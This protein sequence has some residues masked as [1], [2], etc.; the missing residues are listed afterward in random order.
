MQVLFIAATDP[1]GQ[2]H[3]LARLLRQHSVAQARVM[4]LEEPRL[5]PTGSDL[6]RL[7]DGGNELQHLLSTY[8]TVHLVDLVPSQ[9]PLLADGNKRRFVLQWSRRPEPTQ[10][11]EC[12]TLAGRGARIVTTQPGLVDIHD[13]SF[14]PPLIAT[15]Q[16]PW[17]PLAPGTR[18]RARSDRVVLFG[19]TTRSLRDSPRLE[20]LIDSAERS[21]RNI[22]RCRVEF[23]A[24][25]PHRH[26]AQRQ[27]RANIVLAAAET[28]VPRASLEAMAQGL[29]TI[30]DTGEFDP[31]IYAKLAGGA[32]PPVHEI[33]ELDQVLG[34][35][36]PMG[37]PDLAL[38]AWARC[39]LNP[40]RWLALCDRMYRSLEPYGRA[41]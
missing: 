41:A 14:L 8:P 11:R 16:P 29:P 2:V 26:L 35:L 1:H 25:R 22:R 4:L 10:V 7:H 30:L 36:D 3:R 38:Q 23:L 15:W 12:E 17:V 33:D 9:V 6:V 39:A 31:D 20:A 27:R 24:G 19:S 18:G 40:R 32:R 37:E 28:G 34:A 21:A 13:A 5:L